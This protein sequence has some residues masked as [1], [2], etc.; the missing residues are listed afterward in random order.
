LLFAAATYPSYP[1]GLSGPSHARVGHPFTAKVVWFTNA[2]KSNPLVGARVSGRGVS[3]LTNGRGVATITP[4]H[5]GTL[6]LVAT[7]A[8]YVRAA[9]IRVRVTQ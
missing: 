5:T 8:T 4:A 2:G 3:A 7:R 1:L 6:V 9:T